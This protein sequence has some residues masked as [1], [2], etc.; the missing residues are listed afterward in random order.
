M[1]GNKENENEKV[2]K[3]IIPMK[4]QRYLQNKK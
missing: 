3:I 4:G 1:S 2:M